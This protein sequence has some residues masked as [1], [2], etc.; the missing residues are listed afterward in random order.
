MTDKDGAKTRPVYAAASILERDALLNELRES[1]IEVFTGPNDISRKITNETVDLSYEG[2]SAIFNGFPIFV[3][4]KDESRAKAIV[5]R[6]LA[7]AKS[8]EP[9]ATSYYRKFF[10][11]SIYSFGFPVL[12]HI[13]GIYH[14]VKAVQ[15]KEKIR[16][17]LLVISALLYGATLTLVIIAVGQGLAGSALLKNHLFSF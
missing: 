13:L 6:F 2:Y 5:E 1:D 17:G 16:P 3:L 9:S 7:K 12:M 14:L 8:V 4:E 15:G 11:C 10:M